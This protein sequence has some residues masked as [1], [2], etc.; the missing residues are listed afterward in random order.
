MVVDIGGGT[1]DIAVLSMGEIVEGT[2]VRVGGEKFDEAI[3]RF[4]KKEFNLFI[5][6]RS[7]ENIKIQ[8]GSMNPDSKNQQMEARGRDLITGLPRSQYITTRQVARALYEPVSAILLGIK[9]VLGKTP[10]EL[11]GDIV[12]K[13]Q[14]YREAGCWTA[15]PFI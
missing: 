9:Q 13:E 3:A 11:A 10:P 6:E 5:G 12:D 1:T 2:S 7:A 4:I 14:S 8:I 15:W